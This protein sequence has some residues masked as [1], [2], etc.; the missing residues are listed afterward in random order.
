MAPTTQ[1][2]TTTAAPTGS[3]APTTQARTTTAAQ[4][5][6]VSEHPGGISTD[7]EVNRQISDLLGNNYETC[8]E[9]SRYGVDWEGRVYG[10]RWF[11]QTGEIEY[12]GIPLKKL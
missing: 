9:G 7:P 5:T 1:A 11:G 4:T 10:N 6:T 12:G 3:T 2:R 8:H